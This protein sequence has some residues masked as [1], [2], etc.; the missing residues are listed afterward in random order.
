MPRRDCPYKVV[1]NVGENAYRIELPRDMQ[2][3]ATINV[4]DPTPYL[5]DNEEHNE[6]LRTNPLQGG[7]FDAE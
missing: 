3:F 5:E 2:A 1:Q 6:V 4:G 7:G